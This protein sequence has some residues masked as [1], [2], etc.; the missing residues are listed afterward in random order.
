MAK[1]HATPGVF[2]EEKNAFPNSAV[3]V[4]TA[5]PAFIGYT[6]KA[7]RDKKSL[8]LQPTKISNYDE[9]LQFFGG[10]PRLQFEIKGLK[11]VGPEYQLKLTKSYFS[12]PAQIKLFFANGGSDCYI[13]S[14]GIIGKM[15]QISLEELKKGMEPLLKEPEPTLLV[16][17]DAV[18]APVEGADDKESAEAVKKVYELYQEMLK[19]CGE[20]MKN[21][22]AILDVWMNRNKLGEPGYNLHTDISLF[23]NGIGSQHLQWGAAYYPWLHT[24]AVSSSDVSIEHIKNLGSEEDILLIAPSDLIPETETIK[25]VAAFKAKAI[26]RIPSSLALLL[27]NALNQA[28][29]DGTIAAKKA[30]QIKKEE[31]KKIPD[32]D[33]ENTK[34]VVKLNQNLIA[35]SPMY[36]ALMADIRQYLNLLPPSAAI[37][38]IYSMVDNSVGVQQSPA[39]VSM[40]SVVKPALPID[41]KEQEDM[42]IPIDGKAVNAIRTF[43][44]K[45][46]LVWGA[47][48]LDGNSQDWRYI[49]VRR[50]VI[51]IEQ[52]I[53]YALEAYV[54]EPNSADTWANVKAMINNFLTTTWRS[55]A[56][57]GAT[58]EDAFSV[59]VGLG[60][61]MTAQDILDGYM[62]VMVKIA[63]TR[64][65]EFIVI[66]FEQQMQ[67]G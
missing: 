60:T 45:G 43:P 24:T 64:P 61:T 22:F 56:I 9:Y 32:L 44:G 6:E 58:P 55:G 20:D 41:N 47:R 40:G 50:T 17:P 1:I 54:F 66:T 46:V 27:D 53:K 31:F 26:D 12:L 19:H 13:V 15:D 4:P 34:A 33:I 5:I 21:R 52:S 67:G 36:K 2:I 10:L 16:I 8:I 11:K 48:T 35:K 3:P 57:V 14:V 62:R 49:S 37:A 25:D 18:M 63:I 38:G 28:V 30:N 51:F 65:A 59:D 29:L 42:N 39:N 7:M 23:R